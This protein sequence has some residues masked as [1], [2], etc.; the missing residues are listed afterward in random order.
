MTKSFEK[1]KNQE[2]STDEVAIF[3]AHQDSR[4]VELALYKAQKREFESDYDLEDWPEEDM[5]S[6]FY[7][8][9]TEVSV[10]R[11]ESDILPE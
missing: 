7:E 1:I 9:S 3:I 4:N 2:T 6:L 11:S 8:M 5:E 10:N